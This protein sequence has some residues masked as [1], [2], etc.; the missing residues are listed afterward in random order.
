[1]FGAHLY[2][3]GI[4]AFYW[5]SSVGSEKWGAKHLEIGHSY[6]GW[7]SYQRCEGYLVRPVCP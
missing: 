1:M 7:N 6:V 4:Y 3:L 5:S 2:N